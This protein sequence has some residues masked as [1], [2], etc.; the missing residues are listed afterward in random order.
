MPRTQPA[1]SDAASRMSEAGLRSQSFPLERG[2]SR[3]SLPTLLGICDGIGISIGALFE[4]PAKTIVRGD[5]HPQLGGMD[6]NEFLLTARDEQLIQVMRPVQRPGGGSG[7]PY[8]LEAT[9]SSRSCSR[10][11]I[12]TDPWMDRSG[13]FPARRASRRLDT[14]SLM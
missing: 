10:P 7:G 9:R 3:V 14:E 11:L 4:Y 8:G 12:A 2:Y 5:S 6:I 1:P 13:T